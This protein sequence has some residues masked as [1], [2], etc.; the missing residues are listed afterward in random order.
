MQATVSL[1][2]QRVIELFLLPP[3]LRQD[4]IRFHELA[5]QLV[6]L[7]GKTQALVIQEQLFPAQLAATDGATIPA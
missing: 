1:C 2:N 7:A 4:Q 5:P 6:I 3:A